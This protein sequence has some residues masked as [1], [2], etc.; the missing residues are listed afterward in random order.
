MDRLSLHNAPTSMSPVACVQSARHDHT[1]LSSMSK[2]RSLLLLCSAL[3]LD[4]TQFD[5]I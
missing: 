5:E 4:D 3:V 1:H 2:S